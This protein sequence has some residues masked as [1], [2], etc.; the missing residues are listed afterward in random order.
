MH[1]LLTAT[2]RERPLLAIIE[3]VH[4]ADDSSRDLLSL[5]LTRGFSTPTTL[6]VT[7]RSDDLHRRHPLHDVLTVW[8]RLPLVGRV[9][10]GP[11]SGKEMHQLVRSIEAAPTAEEDVQHVIGRAGGNP[12]FAEE[13]VAAGDAG[14]TSDDLVRLLRRR[15]ERL[16]DHARHLVHAAS[17]AGHTVSAD[18]LADVVGFDADTLDD[19]LRETIDHHILESAGGQ[20]FRF[21]H[22]LLGRPSLTTCSRAPAA[23]CTPPGWQPCV[24][25]P[26]S[27]T[28]LTW[29]AT[30]PPPATPQRRPRPRSRLLMRP[31]G[32]VARGTPFACTRPPSPG[33]RTTPADAPRSPWPPPPPPAHPATRCAHSASSRRR[34]PM[35]TR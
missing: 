34:C 15:Q 21:R 24:P 26:S 27:A 25:A 30:P 13:I 3:D 1:A 16:G 23:G 32:W 33:S 10:V 14:R 12:F 2:A 31:C 8:T 6:V 19:A 20:S 17:L 35:P 28:L 29:P 22:A 9:E 18:L 5:L 4:W 11:L 7:Y